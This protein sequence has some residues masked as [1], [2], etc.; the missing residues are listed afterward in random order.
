MK[1]KKTIKKIG[2]IALAGVMATSFAGCKSQIDKS[3]L[4]NSSNKV[5]L[6]NEDNNDLVVIGF[7]EIQ[8]KACRAEEKYGY[9]LT[10]DK[11]SFYDVL[12]D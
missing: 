8:K 1:N 3:T 9:F 11:T 12:A 7:E 4:E 2:A 10:D 6:Q 5:Y